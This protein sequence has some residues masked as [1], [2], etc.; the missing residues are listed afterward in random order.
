[1]NKK[2][3]IITSNNTEDLNILSIINNE[4]KS[5]ISYM[6][7]NNGQ[8]NITNE[9]S[10]FRPI[11]LSELKKKLEQRDW[12]ITERKYI[13]DVN[14]EKPILKVKLT[15]STEAI[16]V[17]DSTNDVSG[18]YITGVPVS[19]P[20][21]ISDNLKEAFENDPN[22]KSIL[23][24]MIGNEIY[25]YN[26]SRNII[27]FV[28]NSM[29]ISAIKYNS[30]SYTNTLNLDKLINKSAISNLSG[31]VDL[32]VQYSKD[33]K[34]INHDITFEAFKF[35]NSGLENMDFIEEINSDVVVEYSN[36]TVRVIPISDNINECIIRNCT[37]TYGNIG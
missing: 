11:R 20:E 17:I 18:K 13:S 9:G 2:L 5:S 14:S 1:M 31:K 32:T 4:D 12:N 7:E 25:I 8:I 33:D 29:I 21:G 34:I 27:D 3:N 37:I 15:P 16:D 26:S 28:N 10:R 19:N 6:T 36:N 30:D 24:S 22:Y 23:D 35:N